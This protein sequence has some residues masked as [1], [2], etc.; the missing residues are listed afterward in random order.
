MCL[1]VIYTEQPSSLLILAQSLS[2]IQSTV[3]NFLERVV[4]SNTN[5]EH[6]V[7]LAQLRVNQD[8]PMEDYPLKVEGGKEDD[9]S[10]GTR[11]FGM[12]QTTKDQMRTNVINEIIST[13][14]DY[15]KHL[16][17]ICEVNNC[18]FE[19]L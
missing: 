6:L 17:D 15:I 16:K 10:S 1:Q 4:F 11:R 19:N 14:R 13:E 18:E 2:A 9:S 12:G 5:S 8:E 3:P 7:C